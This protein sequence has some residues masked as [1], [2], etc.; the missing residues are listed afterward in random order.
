MLQKL[1]TGRKYLRQKYNFVISRLLNLTNQVNMSN[2]INIIKTKGLICFLTVSAFLFTWNPT[3]AQPNIFSFAPNSGAVGDTIILTGINFNTHPD[4]NIVFFGATRAIVFEAIATSLK[5]KVP[6]GATYGPITVLNTTNSLIAYSRNY[7]NPT[8]IPSKDNITKGDIAYKV[9]FPTFTG[10][11]SVVI[12]DIDGDGKSDLAFL[13][14]NTVSVLRNTS[15]TGLISFANKVDFTTIAKPRKIAMGDIDGDGKTDLVIIDPDS[16]LSILRNTSNVGAINFATKV[17]F[18][19]GSSP[20]SV[21]IGDLDQDGRLDLAIGYWDGN[22]V[23]ILRNTGSVGTISFATKVDFITGIIPIAVAI[24]DLNQDGKSDLA[25]VNN[26]NSRVSILRNIS[27]IGTIS[28]ASKLDYA[29]GVDPGSI[30]LGD[31]T[32]DGKLDVAITNYSSRSVSVYRNTSVNGTISFTNKVDIPTEKRPTFLAIG[33]IDGDNKP[34]LVVAAISVYAVSVFRNTGNISTI[35]FAN[36]V[37]FETGLSPNS[38]AIGDIDGDGRSDLAVPNQGNNSI[39]ILRNNPGRITVTGS[40]AD[41]T[42]CIG[43]FSDQ[44]SFNVSGSGLAEDLVIT[45]PYGFEISKNS[46]I[47]FVDS[48][49]LPL[50]SGII[51]NTTLFIRTNDKAMPGSP[52]VHLNFNSGSTNYKLNLNPVI[53][54]YPKVGFWINNDSQCLNNN[55]FLFTNTSTYDF[56]ILSSKWDFGSGNND[57]STRYS[58]IKTYTNANT[59]L[60]K[61]VVTSDGNCKDSISKVVTVKPISIS[62]TNINICPNEL[63]YTW[64]GRNYTTSKIDT[65]FFTNEFGCDSL[66]VLNLTVKPSSSSTN[67]L[68]ICQTELPYIWNGLTFNEAGTQTKSGLINSVGCDS[69][70]TLNLIINPTPN[71]SIINGSTEVARL[72]TS[73]YYVTKTTG[74]I[75]NWNVTSGT[76]DSGIGTNTIRIK[77]N[78]IGIDTLKVTEISDKGCT[79]VQKLLPISIGP[80]VGLNETNINNNVITYPNPFNETIHITLL[81]NIIFDK[82]VIYDLSG[83]EIITTYNNEIDLS[84]LK[85]GIYLIRISDKK[86]NTYSQKISKN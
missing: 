53:Y 34:D 10:Q 12:G 49:S 16:N 1:T 32:G 48:I 26:F 45:A 31:L 24:G 21:A 83:K 81:N 2:N 78:T 54:R 18:R 75:F 77:W 41:F 65:V 13:S 8:F 74:S 15:N 72:D 43:T 30:A 71:T 23:S 68:S 5:V 3:S 66:F 28:F 17:D 63:P 86:G 85:S 82:A 9:D 73:S 58:P 67:T 70:A 37:D 50:S 84:N 51:N 25:V 47:G 62:T 79:G 29:T 69:S 60:V 52:I 46:G 42:A 56:G 19:T 44:Q 36:Q 76:I 35:S 4:S 55:S 20:R 38:L 11:G 14:G 80:A 57:T 22:A 61:L 7:F 64:N 33:N 6:I 40:L 39:S 59:Y 27:T